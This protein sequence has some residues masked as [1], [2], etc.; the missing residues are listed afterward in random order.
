MGQPMAYHIYN[1][2][3]YGNDTGMTELFSLEA[4]DGV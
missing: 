3:L 2:G 1:L 4:P